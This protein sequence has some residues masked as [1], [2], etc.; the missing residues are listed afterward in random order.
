VDYCFGAGDGT[1]SV[2]N[3]S[4]ELDLS[5]DGVP[6]ALSVDFDGDGRSDDALADLD[7]DGS[8]D[9]AV[10]DYAEDSARWFAD[11]GSGTWAIAAAAPGSSGAALRWYDL[12][13]VEQTGGPLVDFDADSAADDQL[14]DVSGDGLAD[15]VVSQ[16]GTVGWIDVDADG[17]MDIKLVDADGDGLADDAAQL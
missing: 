11:D 6:D 5:G 2:W 13:G 12:D 4:P 14:V 7:G 15:R 1:A 8:A 10:L 16:D 17:R 9:H 3:A